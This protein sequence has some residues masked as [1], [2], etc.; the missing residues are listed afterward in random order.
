MGYYINPKEST[1]EDWLREKSLETL[2]KE[3]LDNFDWNQTDVRPVCLVSNGFFNA[4]GVAYDK[5]ELEAFL[6]PGDIRPKIFYAVKISDIL[7]G[8]GEDTK[9]LINLIERGSHEA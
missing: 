5:R 7:E 4:A 1:K 9:S 2:T 3:D 8:V 6:D